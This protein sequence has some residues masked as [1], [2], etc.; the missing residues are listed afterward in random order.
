MYETADLTGLEVVTAMGWPY[1]GRSV[2]NY[3]DGLIAGEQIDGQPSLPFR[4]AIRAGHA[5]HH[6]PVRFENLA[7]GWEYSFLYGQMSPGPFNDSYG[8]NPSAI[9]ATTGSCVAVGSP[10]RADSRVQQVLV[11]KVA[12]A[13]ML[14]LHNASTGAIRYLSFDLGPTGA[15]KYQTYN[16]GMSAGRLMT[17]D[18]LLASDTPGL[19]SL[20]SAVLDYYENKLLVSIEP[21]GQADNLA[22]IPD[23]ID[24]RWMWTRDDMRH[25]PPV[26]ALGRTILA[27]FEIEFNVDFAPT[28]T[29]VFSPAEV[30][31]ANA[32]SSPDH[33][34]D[35]S[36]DQTYE[37]SVSTTGA[38]LDAVYDASGGIVTTS[39]DVSHTDSRWRIKSPVYNEVWRSRVCTTH[40]TVRCGPDSHT[41]A[42]E[43]TYTMR[44][45]G[46]YGGAA[47]LA[48]NG[49]QVFHESGNTHLNNP[50]DLLSPLERAPF[51][52]HEARHITAGLDKYGYDGL[53]PA[54]VVLAISPYSVAVRPTRSGCTHLFS[55]FTHY[56]TKPGTQVER[57]TIG[58]P[59]VLSSAAGM[60]GTASFEAPEMVSTYP[61]LRTV[62]AYSGALGHQFINPVTGQV[63]GGSVD[64]PDARI[65][66]R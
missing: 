18:Q 42:L 14:E 40:S 12:G 3:V 34:A 8:D 32:R 33:V 61:S 65:N 63:S 38:V 1:H 6:Y 64:Y 56:R 54:G 51:P 46:M 10:V 24:S 62:H 7:D 13:Q 27:V 44:H 9:S 4:S 21:T 49:V 17:V 26:S 2:V 41:E 29:R 15:A 19:P 58:L 55:C 60:Q 43:Y 37:W 57:H 48:R 28:I 35:S 59:G 20:K 30:E 5:L 50:E 23:D 52:G 47:T 25:E 45:T 16:S 22:S 53:L 36:S 39:L 11:Y 66:Y 31:G